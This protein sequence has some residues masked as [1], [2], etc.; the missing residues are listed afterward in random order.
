MALP[1][2]HQLKFNIH[3]DAKS[4]M[5]AIEKR[6]GMNK[7]TKKVQK[8]LL[9]QQYENFT[10]SSS[11][12][13]NQIHD[14]LQKLISQISFPRR[15]QS[16]VL[17]KPTHRVENSHSNLEEQDRFGRSNQSNSLQLDNDDLKQ[18][19]DDDLEEMDLKWQMAM[20]TMRARRFFQRTGRNLGANGTTSIRLNMSNVECY[21]CHRRR[22]FARECKSPKDIRN[23]ETQRKNVPM[24]NQQ[25]MPLWHPP[26][27]VFL[28]LIMRNIYAP[29]PDLVFH[30]APTVNETVPTAFNVEPSTT[31]L[32][33]ELSHSNRPFALLIE[34]WVS[35]LEEEY[36]G[37]PTQKAPSFVQTPEHVKTPRPS[38]K[39]DYDYYEK[40][41]VQ[42]PIR[43]HV[44][45]GN[46]QHYARMTHPNPHWHV[47]PTTVLTRS[48]LVP[49]TVARAVTTIVPHINVPR[50][51]I[52]KTI[53]T[54]SHSPLR[55]PINHR[56][57]P[58]PSNF[59]QKVSTVKAPQVN[60]INYG[61][62]PKKALTFLFHVHGNPQHALKDKGVIDSGCSRHMTRNI[63]HLFDFEEINRGYVA[64]GGNPKGGKI[65]DPLGKFDG[66]ADE[67]FL[68]GYSSMNYEP[69]V[70]G[71]QP[72]FSAGIQEHFN[73]DKAREGNVQQYVLFPLWSTGSKDPQNT[74]ADTTFEVKE[75][76]SEVHVS[77]SSS[78]KTKEHDDKPR[79]EAKGKSLIELST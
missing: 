74:N 6:F 63:S 5:E 62:G 43:N 29:K 73:A 37:V 61:L 51:R 68:V 64:F 35:D 28:V 14:K 2:K 12:S 46:H 31:K 79:K 8:I 26:P 40:N 33:K 11:E 78:V 34:D 42:K 24:K 1:D 65:T 15:Y 18:I 48:R 66:K 54:K 76:E 58:K 4:L 20:L 41:M 38:V 44:M 75:P 56:P 53:V 13:L 27:Y 25:T 10:G 19:D 47:V 23:K 77:P 36:E 30:D 50:P 69:V 22:H 21:N 52:A 72:N 3:K 9:K 45:R 55:S 70:V 67:G 17:K 60:A 49:F 16:E 39:P 32:T 57:S 59:P 71:N 7:E